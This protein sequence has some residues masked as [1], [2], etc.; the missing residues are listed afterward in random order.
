MHN[1]HEREA[2]Q[3]LLFKCDPSSFIWNEQATMQYKLPIIFELKEN[4]NRI[5]AI[6]QKFKIDVHHAQTL[7]RHE[8]SNR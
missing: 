8:S 1:G 3:I 7:L 2:P 4:L 5:Y 6:I